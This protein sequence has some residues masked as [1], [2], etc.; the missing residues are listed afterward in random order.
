MTAN[1]SYALA[2]TTRVPDLTDGVHKVRIKYDPNFQ[3]N[4]VLHPSFQ[5]NGYTSWF[6][7]NAD[8]PYGGEGDWGTGFG[9]LYVYVDDMY[10]PVITTPLN[11]DSTLRLEDG[12]MYVGITAATGDNHWQ[13]HD[14]LSWQFK[15]LYIDKVYQPPL[16]LNGEGDYRCVNVDE[17][18]HLPDYDH[19]LRQNKKWGSGSDNIAGWQSGREGFCAFC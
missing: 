18:V 3:E 14:I 1:H 8:F 6:I 10:S 12:R 19:Y 16:I 13:A 15:S 7:Q 2:T 4:A 9:L 5:I 11:L 17:C